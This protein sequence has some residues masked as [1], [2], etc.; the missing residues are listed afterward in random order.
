MPAPVAPRTSPRRRPNSRGTVPGASPGPAACGGPG[1]AGPPAVGRASASGS[2]LGSVSRPSSA[3]TWAQGAPA[4]GWRSHPSGVLLSGGASQPAAGAMA[5]TPPA[6]ACATRVWPALARRPPGEPRALGPGEQ[7]STGYPPAQAQAA[8]LWS[9]RRVFPPQGTHT[10]EPAL[11]RGF[12]FENAADVTAS[13]L[14]AACC[15]GCLTR[16]DGVGWAMDEGV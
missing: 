9:L 8:A 11:R 4:G 6:A 16:L 15:R 1:G 13:W 12:T 3:P 5:W 14:S 7:L 2:S 10:L